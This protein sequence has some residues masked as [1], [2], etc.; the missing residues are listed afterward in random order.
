VGVV[1]AAAA[2]HAECWSAFR[3][4]PAQCVVPSGSCEQHLVRLVCGARRILL[5]HPDRWSGRHAI[6][7]ELLPTRYVSVAARHD[8]VPAQEIDQS[9]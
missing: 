7:V 8:A 9:E 5:A 3:R 6:D 4:T 2:V 1:R